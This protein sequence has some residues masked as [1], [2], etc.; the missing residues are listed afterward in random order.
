MQDQVAPIGGGGDVEEGQFVGALLVVAAGDLD[1]VAGIAQ[2]DKVHPLDHTAAG[3][4]KTGNNAL[5]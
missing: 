3:D 5:G 1:R 4:I 2:F